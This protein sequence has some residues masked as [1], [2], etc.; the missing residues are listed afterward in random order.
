MRGLENDLV[1]GPVAELEKLDDDQIAV[2]TVLCCAIS[3]AG[4]PEQT[5][6]S[7]AHC[8]GAVAE[9]NP[10]HGIGYALAGG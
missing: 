9:E 5:N 6:K 1:P 10:G 7:D 8:I 4:S 3:L 2:S